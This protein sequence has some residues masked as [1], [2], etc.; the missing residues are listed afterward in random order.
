M[1]TA[2]LAPILLGMAAMS[3]DIGGYASDRRSLQNKADAIAL[4]ASR[5]LPDA[6]AARATAQAYAAKNNIA[7]SEVTFAV[8]PQSANNP[9]PKVTVDVSRPHD[10]SFI[11]VIGIASKSVGAHAAAIKTSP[12]GVGGLM[13]WSVEESAVTGTPYGQSLVVKYDANNVS[14]GN[15]GPLAFDGTGSSTYLDTIDNGSIS[16]VCAQGV[17]SCTT[18]SRECSGSTCPTEPGNKVGPTRNGVDDRIAATDASCDTFAEVFSGPVDGKY[19][20]NPACN[21]WLAGSKPSERVII[22]PIIDSLCNGR[23]DVTVLGF[24]LMFLEGYG[25]GRCTGNSCEIQARFVNAD[26]T[27]N[28]LTGVY[29]PNSSIQFTRLSE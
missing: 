21:P 20:L 4:A 13:P 26:V 2:L 17:A 8:I 22:V 27:V 28:A 19:Q 7:W 11:R 29:D 5:D 12:G 10:F 16:V 9:N 25:P 24:T 15:F 14:N 23:C 3:V 1:F 6:S 18:V